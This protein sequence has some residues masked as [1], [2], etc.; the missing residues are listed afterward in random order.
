MNYKD[1][2]PYKDVLLLN[3]DY[4]AIS[5]IKWKRAVVLLI[6]NRVKMISKRVVCL[7]NYVKIPYQKLLSVKPTKN[8]VKRLGNYACAYC[9]SFQ[10]LTIDH[11]IPLSR[12]GEH[13]FKNL[14]CACRKCNEEKGPRTPQEWGKLPYIP[15]Y[16][17]S[18][19]LEMIV[20]KSNVD[21]W[22]AYIYN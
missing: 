11:M 20:K 9:G 4:N 19:K 15:Q 5:I 22:Q 8:L 18:S 14:V 16:K 6:K 7:L 13:T 1:L 17:P 21:E 2:I 12:G 10:N 3:S